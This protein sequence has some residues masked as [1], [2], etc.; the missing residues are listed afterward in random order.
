MGTSR[1]KW[2]KSEMRGGTIILDA[3][4][5]FATEFRDEIISDYDK[6][7]MNKRQV[8]LTGWSFLDLLQ[9]IGCPKSALTTQN[10]THGRF[11][12]AY[13]LPAFNPF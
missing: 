1:K 11:G 13:A 4:G 6:D 7:G 12:M 9:K 5:S 10:R 3:K 2:T 8:E